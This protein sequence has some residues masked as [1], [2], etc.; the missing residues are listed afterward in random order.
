MLIFFVA[1]LNLIAVSS[2]TPPLP[3]LRAFAALVERGSIAAAADALSLTQGAVGHQIRALEDFVEQP[4][5]SRQGRRLVLTEAGRIYGYQ[6]RQ[7]ID[8]ISEATERLKQA[9]ERATAQSG[10]IRIAALPSFVQGWLLSRLKRF[11]YLYPDIRLTLEA[12]MS[13]VEL[14]RGKVDAA[15]RFGHG[16]W[17][18]VSAAPILH[19]RL[20][21]VAA[22]GY[23]A[24]GTSLAK[25]LRG[26]LLHASESWS[27]WLASVGD[28]GVGLRPA[29]AAMLFT[30]STHLLEAAR[31]GMGVALTRQSIAD[32]ALARGDLVL[33]HTHAALHSSHYYWVTPTE[34]THSLPLKVFSSWLFGECER[35]AMEQGWDQRAGSWQS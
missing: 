13:L 17:P 23:L 5:I 32:A 15:I 35:Y 28:E 25:V 2:R 33:A 14:G 9:P 1:Y 4:L 19:D 26:Q 22:P 18:D 27:A 12:S 6:I 30:D 3:A 29:R 21:L 8:D 11:R 31:L 24:G 10:H 7:A 34:S 20:V 16:R